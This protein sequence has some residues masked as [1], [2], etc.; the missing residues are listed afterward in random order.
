MFKS[1]H[2]YYYK[3]AGME[4]AAMTASETPLEFRRHLTMLTIYF[5]L[6]SGVSSPADHCRRCEMQSDCRGT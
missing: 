5:D 3:R 6:C 4:R 2:R 1:D